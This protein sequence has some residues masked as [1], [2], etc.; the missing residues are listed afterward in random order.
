[1]RSTA[2]KLANSLASVFDDPENVGLAVG[3]FLLAGIYIG[4]WVA[5]AIIG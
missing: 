2:R 3:V 1:M 4:G 5:T